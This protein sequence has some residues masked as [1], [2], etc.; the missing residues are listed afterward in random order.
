MLLILKRTEGFTVSCTVTFYN[1]NNEWIK[2][3]LFFNK[4]NIIIV[5]NCCIISKIKQSMM[6]W[7]KISATELQW[8][9]HPI[10]DYFL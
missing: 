3:A 10:G 6:Y 1:I 4:Y 2:C 9:H 8:L 5:A 7:V